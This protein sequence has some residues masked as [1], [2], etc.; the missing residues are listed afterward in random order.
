MK[1]FQYDNLEVSKEYLLTTGYYLLWRNEDFEMDNQVIALFDVS[2]FDLPDIKTLVLHLEYGVIIES[3]TTKQLINELHKSN[4]FVCI[5]SKVL[6]GL[7]SIKRYVPFVHAYQTYM[8]INGGT[9]QNTDWISPN[10]IACV[11]TSAGMLHI[12]DINGNMASLKSVKGNLDQRLHD[13]A[14]LSRANFMFLECIVNWG[15]C[16]L[17]PPSELGLLKSFENCNCEE[18]LEIESVVKD[19]DKMVFI[20]KKAILSNLGID[21]IQR[22]ELFKFYGQNLSRFKKYY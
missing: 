11:W 12:L 2:M 22:I 1:F 8:P 10:L 14:L 21:K 7:F 5:F 19:L 6:A 4:G 13:V 16:Q 3:R 17:Q 18:H 20:L 15:H 9:R